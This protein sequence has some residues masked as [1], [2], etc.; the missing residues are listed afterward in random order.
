M[1]INT[2]IQIYIYCILYICVNL[3]MQYV[4]DMQYLQNSPAVVTVVSPSHW[5]MLEL[6]FISLQKLS[7]LSLNS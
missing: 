7:F 4:I 3:S 1:H 6:L 5:L 2:Y